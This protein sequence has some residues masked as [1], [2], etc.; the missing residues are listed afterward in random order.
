MLNITTN[1]TAIKNGVTKE[2][3]ESGRETEKE[4]NV[5]PVIYRSNLSLLCHR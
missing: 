4:E 5:A 3:N 1:I 2:R